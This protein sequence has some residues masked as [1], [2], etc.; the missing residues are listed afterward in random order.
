MSFA[1][2]RGVFVAVMAAGLG[3]QPF[4]SASAA[5][6]VPRPAVVT[7]TLARLTIEL[8]SSVRATAAVRD[9]LEQLG[10]EKIRTLSSTSQT[11]SIKPAIAAK[12]PWRW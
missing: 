10:R 8:P 1:L 5:E 11:A 7:E 3:C 9:P 12:R 6:A 4:W 2:S